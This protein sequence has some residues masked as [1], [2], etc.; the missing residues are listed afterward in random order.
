MANPTSHRLWSLTHD[1]ERLVAGTMNGGLI[2]LAKGEGLPFAES[3]DLST[4]ERLRH[5]MLIDQDVIFYPMVMVPAGDGVEI[6][7]LVLDAR[8][9]ERSISTMNNAFNL[10]E[11]SAIDFR[12]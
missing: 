5:E 6:S 1:G 11:S 4:G 12:G 10:G 2:A 7:V 3:W 9:P 8:N